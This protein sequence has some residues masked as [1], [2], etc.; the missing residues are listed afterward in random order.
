MLVVPVGYQLVT[1]RRGASVVPAYLAGPINRGEGPFQWS[2][3]LSGSGYPWQL[4]CGCVSR[5]SVPSR[6]YQGYGGAVLAV[7]CVGLE[8]LPPATSQL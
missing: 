7:L 2:W 4:A 1:S 3:A 6:T 8:W 5:P